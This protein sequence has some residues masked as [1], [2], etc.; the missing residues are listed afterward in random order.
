[1]DQ[2]LRVLQNDGQH[3]EEIFISPFFIPIE[4]SFKTKVNQQFRMLKNAMVS[5]VRMAELCH[6]NQASWAHE[7]N[8]LRAT[9][10][11]L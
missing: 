11:N 6:P 8:P 5:S 4:V 7:L 1:M 2:N 3:Q 10:Q 9:K